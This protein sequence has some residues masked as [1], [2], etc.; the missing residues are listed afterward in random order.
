[1]RLRASGVDKK[2]LFGKSDPFVVISRANNRDWTV[3][4]RTEVVKNTLNPIWKPFE[5]PVSVLCNGNHDRPLKVSAVGPCFLCQNLV[6]PYVANHQVF[7]PF[8]FKV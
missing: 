1:M 3:V 5:I 2:D 4:H 6:S 8:F 7:F